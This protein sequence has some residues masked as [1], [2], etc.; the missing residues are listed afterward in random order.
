M[1]PV[2]RENE[3][4]L[5][6]FRAMSEE[7]RAAYRMNRHT[8]AVDM[9]VMACTGL[10][11][12]GVILVFFFDPGGE[13]V[14]PYA[15]FLRSLHYSLPAFAIFM[16]ASLPALKARVGW[17]PRM[18][19]LAWLAAIG[20]GLAGSCAVRFLN[21]AMDASPAARYDT[22]VQDKHSSRS[23]RHG[24]RRRYYLDVDNWRGEGGWYPLP[25][26]PEEYDRVPKGL[27]YT[28]VTHKGALGFEWIQDYYPSASRGGGQPGQ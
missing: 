28:V 11:G 6:E 10:L 12:I 15:V 4:R 9:L 16:L 20:F 8:A 26:S 2:S 7:Q 19:R 25:V 18:G 27:A 3:A 13:P 22:K 24:N 5:E 21:S 1:E 17:D 23:G 14:D